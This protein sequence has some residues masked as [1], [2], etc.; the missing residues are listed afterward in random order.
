[1]HALRRDTE[2]AGQARFF[3][4]RL[5]Q[6]GDGEGQ[7]VLQGSSGTRPQRGP[8]PHPAAGA[9]G[10][11]GGAGEFLGHGEQRADRFERTIHTSGGS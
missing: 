5:E 1:M 10:L 8:A 6:G 3:P 2:P 7:R 9:A 11:A 4:A